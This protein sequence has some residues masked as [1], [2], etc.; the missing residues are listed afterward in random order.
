MTDNKPHR[1]YKFQAINRYSIANLEK[2]MIWCSKPDHFNDPFDTSF[3]ISWELS[4][5]ALLE[6]YRDVFSNDPQKDK[7]D[8]LYLTDGIVNQHFREDFISMGDSIITDILSM[9][10][11][12][13]IACFSESH[14]NI[15]MWSHYANS[16]K[17]MCLEFMPQLAGWD[18]IFPVVYS[19]HPPLF[20][21]FSIS[22]SPYEFVLQYLLTKAFDW[23]YEKEWRMIIEGG[24]T[25]LRYQTR[26]LSSIYLGCKISE[27]DK[28]HL[29]SI[30]KNTETQIFQ[31]TLSSLEFKLE[32][33]L[34]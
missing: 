6:I 30:L 22:K 20:N 9:I 27:E 28:N 4:D 16:H 15:L 18:R 24:D 29:I 33:K 3:P 14:T 26:V 17:G 31:M 21:P 23:Q 25:G 12:S 34:L 19:N 11:N 2:S 13:G 1:L 7:F 8:S 10:Q 32:A 5:H